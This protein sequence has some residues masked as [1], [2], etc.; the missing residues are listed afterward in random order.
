MPTRATLTR[1]QM[2]GLLLAIP[3]VLSLAAC[4]DDPEPG[5]GA[6]VDP[7]IARE[8]LVAE[9]VDLELG[10]TADGYALSVFGLTSEAGWARPR[11]RPRGERPDTAGFFNFE[12]VALPPTTP[13]TSPMA[14]LPEARRVRADRLFTVEFLTGLSG[15]RIWTTSGSADVTFN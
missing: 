15:L 5:L 6:P 9:L 4:A 3:V 12:F 10:R 1:R 7:L 11:L 14:Q 8:E 2:G 13:S